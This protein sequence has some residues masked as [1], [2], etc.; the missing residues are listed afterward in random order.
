MEISLILAGC[1]PA[2]WGDV[3]LFVFGFLGSSAMCLVTG[4]A[5]LVCTAMG[6]TTAGRWL[7]SLAMLFASIAAGVLWWL[8]S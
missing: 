7:V 2:G 1:S 3:I 4:V 6:K 8:R 5:G